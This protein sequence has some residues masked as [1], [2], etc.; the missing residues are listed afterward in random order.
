MPPADQLP[1]ALAGELAEGDAAEGGR[2]TGIWALAWRRFLRH[3]LALGA[4]AVLL[5]LVLSAL[6]A[7]WIAPYNP[8]HGD[9]AAFDGPPSSAHLLGTDSKGYDVLSRLLYGGR[10]SLL[11]GTASMIAA[12][13][14]GTTVGAVAGY[15][16][17][18][19]DAVLMRLT[20]VVLAFPLY[21]LLFVVS[22]FFAGSSGDA[23]IALIVALLLLVSWTTVARLVR[24]QFLSLKER[25]FVQAARAVGAGPLAIIVRQLLPNAIAPILVNATLL[26]GNNIILESVL[27]FFG[28][29]VQLPTASWGTMLADGRAA[30]AYAPWETIYPGLA[31]LLTVLSI[32]LVGDGL[33][34]ALDPTSG[35]GASRR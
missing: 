32:N 26:V 3:R 28:F 27:S 12:I 7:P 21:L 16:G 23:S 4:S 9:F 15:F 1:P 24:G 31:I 33:R 13:G 18:W 10:I 5:L 17:G 19:A 11:I 2:G 29:G 6:A 22:A 34:D 20:D 35:G 30:Q 25:E 8:N 14:V